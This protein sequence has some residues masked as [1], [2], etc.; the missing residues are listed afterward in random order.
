MMYC[1][2]VTAV[3]EARASDERAAAP[4]CCH[5]HGDG[6]SRTAA[7][8][9]GSP[10]TPSTPLAPGY[11]TP[12]TVPGSYV[13]DPAAGTNLY[14]TATL[15]TFGWCNTFDVRSFENRGTVRGLVR[16]S[17]LTPV[18]LCVCRC[19]QYRIKEVMQ[20]YGADIVVD[21]KILK[22]A[23]TSN[24]TAIYKSMWAKVNVIRASM[25]LVKP[26]WSR[27]AF[28]VTTA[29][30]WTGSMVNSLTLQRPE[31][32]ATPVRARVFC[33]LC[34]RGK[35]ER[36]RQCCSSSGES[37]DTYQRCHHNVRQCD[38]GNRR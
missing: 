35:D 13:A 5:G 34:L 7:A 25:P 6:G 29:S 21:S 37:Q 4:S 20:R 19:F 26:D 14:F 22:G 1:S 33:A 12:V 30:S 10:A 36:I 2:A 24:V 32:D 17:A 23:V 18:R 9:A 8:A 3:V 11:A 27:A 16:G 31:I 38:G 15:L 28:N